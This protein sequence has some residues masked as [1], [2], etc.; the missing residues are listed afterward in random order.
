[1][2]IIFMGTPDFAVECLKKLYENNYEI[3]GV[4]TSPDN[5]AGRGQQ[6]TYSA[7][8]Q[9][10][11]SKNLNILQPTNLKD[12]NF[13]SELKNLRADLQII[14]AFRMLP[15]VV[16]SM[17]PLGT[18]NLH[19]SLLPQ[20]RGA[21]P[22]NWAI[23]NGETKTGL[24][25]FFLDEKIDTGNIIFQEEIEINFTDNAEILHDKLMFAGS[26]LVIKTVK[27]IMENNYNKTPQKQLLKTEITLKSAPKIYKENCKI[28]WNLEALQVYNF[29]RG[30]STYPAAWTE[31]MNTESKQITSLKIFETEIVNQQHSK[32]AGEFETDNKNYL[33]IFTSSNSLLIKSLQL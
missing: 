16:W 4:V 14:V 20:Y 28:N 33:K 5:P 31:I 15:A 18:F 19:A 27:S 24:T 17:P 10:A 13:L 22:I 29:V 26:E 8:K 12:E 25:T 2:R 21:A 9:Y 7:V 30:L 6:I 23:I 32:N 1:M 11:L 3:V